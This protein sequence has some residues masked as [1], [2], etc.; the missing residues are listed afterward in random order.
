VTVLIGATTTKT[1][2]C[3]EMAFV[4]GRKRIGSLD[5]RQLSSPEAGDELGRGRIVGKK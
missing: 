5:P 2:R 4:P 3:D 1:N